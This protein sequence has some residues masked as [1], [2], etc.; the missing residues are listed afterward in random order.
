MD[1]NKLVPKDSGT[2]GVEVV[3]MPP[4]ASVPD[5]ISRNHLADYL[6]ILRKHQW[7]IV[8]SAGRVTIVSIATFLCIGSGMTTARIEIDRENTAVSCLFR[9]D[10][11]T[12]DGHG[13]L[14]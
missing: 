11:T 5:L 6:L 10:S 3:S 13:Q 1:D 8:S 12:D 9:A 7:L 2:G 14:Y 4:C